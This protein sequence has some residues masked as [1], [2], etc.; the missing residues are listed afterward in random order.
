MRLANGKYVI[1]RRLGGGG[2]A[3]VFLGRTIGAEGFSRPVAIKCV[4]P[5]FSADE[6]FA[7]AFKDEAMLTSRLTHPNI[8]SVLDFSRDD[9]GRLFLVM[10]VVN[11]ADLDALLDTGPLPFSTV[12]HLGI[13]ILRGL[14][15][16]HDLP[17]GS[18]SVRGI[19]HRDV[20]PHNV[21]LSWAGEVK[22]SDFGIA[23][24]RKATSATKSILI[25]GKPAY[26]SP[27]Q[28]QGAELDGRSDLFAVGIVLYQ[29]LCLVPLFSGD[30]PLAMMSQ[31]WHA[32]IPD[33]QTKRPEIPR[34]L[35]RVVSWLLQRDPSQRPQ[36]AAAAIEA[37]QACRDYPKDGRQELAAILA[38]RFADRA[39][40]RAGDLA[41]QRIT[42]Y[43]KA[44]QVTIVAPVATPGPT[45]TM[46]PGRGSSERRWRRTVIGSLL[47]I[48]T[49]VTAIAAITASSGT[50]EPA[51][52]T[53][54]AGDGPG[55]APK[56]PTPDVRAQGTAAP[57]AVP[58][59]PV[60]ARQQDAELRDAGAAAP[61]AGS[62][63]PS[64]ASVP[65]TALEQKAAPAAPASVPATALEQKAA[66]APV[67]AT[68]VKQKSAPAAPAPG[69]ARRPSRVAPK[70]DGIREIQ[71][72]QDR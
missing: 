21:L 64:S 3:E 57:A 7:K 22:V 32:P 72:D 11:G 15:H 49:T 2:M 8:V 39:P 24:A 44:A 27:E 14:G 52:T 28:A 34:D 13:E 59:V 36:T 43:Q 10:E 41:Q 60:A 68:A 46:P 9:D 6:D 67:Q 61:V 70:P 55:T 47:V 33:P 26:M 4:L 17:I 62:P 16:A 23:K 50:T 31:V 54:S 58:V 71:L 20:S 40:V 56:P 69:P 25:K 66:P 35:S 53:R 42:A 30:T 29:A 37:L 5:A 12:I 65:A 18:D 45:M 19:I 51:A 48:G 38:K 1:D 63:S